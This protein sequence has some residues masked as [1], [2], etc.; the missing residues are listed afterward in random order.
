MTRLKHI[1]LGSDNKFVAVNKDGR[2]FYGYIGGRSITNKNQIVCVDSI[3]NATLLEDRED[4]EAIC[5]INKAFEDFKIIEVT[6]KFIVS[7]DC[8]YCGL[9]LP[10][11][12]KAFRTIK[13]EIHGV[14]YNAVSM[15]YKLV[16]GRVSFLSEHY[17][18][19]EIAMTLAEAQDLFTMLNGSSFDYMP[20]IIKLPS[21]VKIY[22]TE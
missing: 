20:E 1:R 8:D 3:V 14:M 12:R 11:G 9:S 21:T 7:V 2:Y 17:N 18:D 22:P 6:D 13:A 10:D 16:D 15:Y 19:G 5:K 4:A